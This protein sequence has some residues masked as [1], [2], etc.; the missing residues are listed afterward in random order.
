MKETAFTTQR[1]DHLGIVA[2]MCR[3]IDL[4]NQ[5]DRHVGRTE[6]K[7]SVGQA[8]QAM[9]LNA[10]GF[11]GRALY[12]TPEF[13]ANKPI[14]VLIGAGIKAEDLNDD[15]LGRALDLL[16]E[17]DVTELFARV[18]SHALQVFGIEH[19]FHH[20]DSTS[21]SLDGEYATP[22]EDPHAIKITEG[23]S[24]DH[25]PDLKQVVVS[26]ICTYQSAIPV[27]FEAL[28]GNRVDKESFAKTIQAY[29]DQMRLGESSYFIADSALYSAKN[30]GKLSR[31]KW[32][33]RVPETLN[34]AK[35]LSKA[36]FPEAMEA[37]KEEGYRFFEVGSIYGGV[38]QR[39]LLVFSQAAAE[40]EQARLYKQVEKER[41]QA[42]K[43]LGGL[44]RQE[45]SNPESAQAALSAM[46]KGFRFH[47]VE[48][49]LQ[50]VVHYVGR[51][52]P[53]VG[54]PPDRVGWKVQ[55]Q[56][57]ER[58]QAVWDEL[59]TKGKFILATNELDEQKLPPDKMLTAY[60]GQGVSVEHGFRFLKDPL[61]FASSLFLDKP[62]RIMALLMVMGLSLL[63][64]ALAE[65]QVRMELAR[66]DQTIPNQNGKPT[67]RPTL[68]RIFQI[69][70]GID[71]LWV[72][73]SEGVL[74]VLVNLKPIHHQI[75]DLL[76]SEV[77]ACYLSDA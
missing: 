11:V 43:E 48:V 50:G 66:R 51:G 15:S 25:R 61:F 16:Y 60:K 39:W 26:L 35:H 52:K 18:A 55:G 8:V 28:D 32:L 46:E 13:F 74:R 31:V 3:K 33:T 57:I 59:V 41:Q 12:L 77:K 40:R 42:E 49:H 6:R 44:T 71:I 73:G 24:K 2:G 67:H 14:E 9:M 65:R 37:A 54:Q 53:K 7:V 10:L 17:S 20:L 19:E 36:I 5:I 30:I 1:L 72:R 47:H 68:R 4:I 76:G 70:E 22:S 45:F 23:Y 62:E 75:L 56:L 21:F 34:A 27:W 29:V 69:F 64:Y 63:V 58:E 38:K